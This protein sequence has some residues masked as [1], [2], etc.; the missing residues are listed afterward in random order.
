MKPESIT[1][2]QNAERKLMLENLR[3]TPIVHV[4]CQQSNVSR[5]TYYRWRR[6]DEQF[7]K[8]S[9]HAMKEGEAMINDL[10]ES[11]LISLIKEK[12]FSAIQLWLKQH[13]DK[14]GNK[15]EVTAKIT[16]EDPLTPEGA[17]LIQK[18]LGTETKKSDAQS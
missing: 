16:T 4:A 11:Q 10:S 13:H 18:V 2:R 12:N 17:L 3:K 9:D 5:T 14:Y 15:M 8:D 6:E 1:K 7:L